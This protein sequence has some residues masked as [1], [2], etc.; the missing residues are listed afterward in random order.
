MESLSVPEIQRYL[1]LAGEVG[2]SCPVVDVHVH[3]TEVI[4]RQIRY[5]PAPEGAETH[6]A[7][8]SPFQPPRVAA[9]RLDDASRA[10]SRFDLRTRNRVSRLIFTSAYEHIGPRVLLAH[11]A[12]ARVSEA[13]L[14]PVAPS[15][16]GVEDQMRALAATRAAD[17]RFAIAY[18]VPN[19]IRAEDIAGDVRM[20]V[21]AYGVRAVKLHPNLSRIDLRT[22]EGMERVESIQAACREAALPLM[23]HGGRSPIL[24]DEWASGLAIVDNLAHVDW[25]R[26]GGSVV[27]AHC[28]FFGCDGEDIAGTAM[29]VLQTILDRHANVLVDTSG[30]PFGILV[31]ALRHIDPERIVFGSDALYFPMWQAVVT[32][33]H[34]LRIAGR[35]LQESFAQIASRNARIRLLPGAPV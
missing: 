26:S 16:G 25:G 22:A 20:A 9:L 3:A 34:A 10:A 28:G 2:R 1:D 23:V 35:P 17:P 27:I 24:D 29:P 7:V 19:P 30:L 4:F 5:R 15:D 8:D 13:L 32:L 14:L 11:M 33:L 31:Q 6:S 18:S 12:L 21:R